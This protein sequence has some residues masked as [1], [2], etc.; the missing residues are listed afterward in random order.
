MLRFSFIIP[1]YNRPDEIK[2]LLESFLSVIGN[3]EFEIVIVEDGSTIPCESV[4]NSYSDQLNISYHVKPNSGPGA[5]RNYGMQKA[6]GDYF[7]ILDSDCLVPKHYFTTVKKYLNS[8][9]TDC[10]SLIHI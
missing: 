1:V 6:S 9:Y 5:S 4:I 10:L 7:I 3:D 2:E 8:N